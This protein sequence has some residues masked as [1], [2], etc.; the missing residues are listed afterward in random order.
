[1]TSFI[2]IRCQAMCVFLFPLSILE[3]IYLTGQGSRALNSCSNWIVGYASIFSSKDSN[4]SDKSD[5]SDQLMKQSESD[6][7]DSD[8]VVFSGPDTAITI[9]G[10]QWLHTYS[11]DLPYPLIVHV[12]FSGLMWSGNLLLWIV[13]LPYTTTFKASVV[14]SMHPLLLVLWLVLMGC[15]VSGLEFLGVAVSFGGILIVSQE[16]E[17]ATSGSRSVSGPDHAPG[18][19]WVGLVL[20]FASAACEVLVVFNRIKTKKYVPLMQVQLATEETL[21]FAALILV[22]MCA[23]HSGDDQRGGSSVKRVVPRL[24]KAGQL[25]GRLALSG[26]LGPVRLRL[27]LQ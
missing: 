8:T 26:R 21:S 3:H 6:S 9:K 4:H 25:G 19:E 24:G 22:L 17:A 2:H 14:A 27:D 7:I 18:P 23:V 16:R 10:V 5:Q 12:I 20:C 1:M 15:Q 11:P 13:A